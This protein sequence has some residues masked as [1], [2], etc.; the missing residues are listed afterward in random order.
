MGGD[1]VEAGGG[2]NGPSLGAGQFEGVA[3]A[4]AVAEQVGG[5][6][7]I[8]QDDAGQGHS[9]HPVR[10]CDGGFRRWHESDA[11]WHY[12]HCYPPWSAGKIHP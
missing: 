7:Q 9:D 1:H 4:T 5:S 2:G 3:G 8:E 12:C 6:G 11:R 10:G